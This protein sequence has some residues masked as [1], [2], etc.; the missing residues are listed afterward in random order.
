MATTETGGTPS[1]EPAAPDL[2]DL[3]I[4]LRFGADGWAEVWGV[5]EWD[6]ERIAAV[7][8]FAY[9]RGYLDA[10]REPHRGQLCRDHGFPTPRRQP[11]R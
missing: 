2:L 11:R 4:D 9:G 3:D 1:G 10:L 8:R 7:L 5:H 6:D